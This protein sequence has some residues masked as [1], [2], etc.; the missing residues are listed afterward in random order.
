MEP[1]L[2]R[3]STDDGDGGAP[4]DVAALTELIFENIDKG[5]TGR[6]SGDSQSTHSNIILFQSVLGVDGRIITYEDMEIEVY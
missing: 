3:A 6:T 5:T 1:D 4:R 2:V